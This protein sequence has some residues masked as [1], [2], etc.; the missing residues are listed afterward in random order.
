MTELMPNFCKELINACGFTGVIEKDVK[1]GEF[2]LN[3]DKKIPCRHRWVFDC[4]VKEP[5]K[6]YGVYA[7][8]LERNRTSKKWLDMDQIDA[9]FFLVDL[10][11]DGSLDAREVSN[12]K[13]LGLDE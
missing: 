1:P 2:Y 8:L 11:K 4:E 5:H 9:A 6:K 10:R 12:N 3:L 13:Y 7:M